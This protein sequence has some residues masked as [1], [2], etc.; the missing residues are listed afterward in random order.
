MNEDQIRDIVR[1]ELFK[2]LSPVI[3]TAIDVLT[4]SPWG[5]NTLVGSIFGGLQGLFGTEGE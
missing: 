4:D 2:C 1:D 5:E 3:A